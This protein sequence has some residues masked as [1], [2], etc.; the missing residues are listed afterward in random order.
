MS[1]RGFTRV[2]S[3]ELKYVKAESARISAKLKKK[4][5]E[6]D[7]TQEELAELLDVTPE[8][9]RFIEQNIRVPS[10]P[11]LIRLAKVLKLELFP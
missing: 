5:I 3:K 9:V 10:F 7:Y 2:P 8:T 1:T 4:R 11:M 6:L